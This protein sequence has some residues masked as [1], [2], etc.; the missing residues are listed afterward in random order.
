[1]SK[2]VNAEQLKNRVME[3]LNKDGSK[4]AVAMGHFFC[5]MV[6]EMPAAVTE[7]VLCEE[8]KYR[9][10]TDSGRVMCCRRG[11]KSELTGGW[12]GLTATDNDQ[13]CSYGERMNKE[14]DGE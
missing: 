7:V 14:G 9:V 10:V 11:G 3:E 1:M 12:Y 2:Y 5:A 4:F 6:D 8:C 13:F